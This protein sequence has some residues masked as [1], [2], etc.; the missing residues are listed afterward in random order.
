KQ[1]VDAYVE[2]ARRATEIDRMST[3]REKTGVFT[4]AYCI[5]HLNGDRIPIFI[6]DYALATYGTGAVMGVPAHDQRDFEFAEKY[7]LPVK[8]VIAPPDYAEEPLREAYVDEGAMVNSG[9]F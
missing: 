6:A 4:G 9:R 5:N 3:E 2:Q 7:G 8:V 1:E